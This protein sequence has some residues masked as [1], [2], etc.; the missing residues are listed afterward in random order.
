LYNNTVEDKAFY[1]RESTPENRK[2]KA[3]GN[4]LDKLNLIPSVAEY[5]FGIKP[6][7]INDFADTY[8][9]Y[10]ENFATIGEEVG[11]RKIITELYKAMD[12]VDQENLYKV[13]NTFIR[14]H[15]A[16]NS[17]W[18]QLSTAG[19][20]FGNILLLYG[21]QQLSVGNSVKSPY[22]PLVISTAN[23][24]VEDAVGG[25]IITVENSPYLTVQ[26]GDRIFHISQERVKEFI[27]NPLNP[28]ARRGDAVN[29][30][31]YGVPNGSEIIQ[32]AGKGH[33]R[34]PTP[35]ELEMYKEYFN[36]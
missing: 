13:F 25:T 26:K 20:T 5:L 28:N 29:F 17:K 11:G 4:S 9:T 22:L 33:K 6:N 2:P 7:E 19:I 21:G 8:K 36:K 23:K 31:K 30:K 27:K 18:R 3:D 34:T 10:Y 24:G 14:D 1:N 35:C 12:G 15:D 16:K 32:G